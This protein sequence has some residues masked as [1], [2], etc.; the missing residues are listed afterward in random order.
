MTGDAHFDTRLISQ[1]KELKVNKNLENVDKFVF[2]T[3]VES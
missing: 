3:R 1:E 2:W